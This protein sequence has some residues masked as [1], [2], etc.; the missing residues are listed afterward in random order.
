MEVWAAVRA[1]APVW[2]MGSASAIRGTLV[3]CARAA[4]TV[5]TGRRAPTTAQGLVQ[6][7]Y[8]QT[9][10]CT[11]LNQFGVQLGLIML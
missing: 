4:P 1:M 10:V 8:F 5:T 7:C 11:S 9:A 3:L 2:E 6:V